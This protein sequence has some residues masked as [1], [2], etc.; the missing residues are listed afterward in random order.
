MGYNLPAKHLWKMAH[1]DLD[2]ARAEDV[3]MLLALYMEIDGSFHRLRI[4]HDTN[5]DDDSGDDSVAPWH[6][7]HISDPTHFHLRQ[8]DSTDQTIYNNMLIL[9]E[10][11]QDLRDTW[12]SKNDEE[13][14]LNVPFNVP[15]SKRLRLEWIEVEDLAKLSGFEDA[16]LTVIDCIRL[17]I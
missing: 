2:Q 10:E 8:D 9:V 11:L 17:K 12:L 3:Q 15:S 14:P 4:Q 13:D 5:N 6:F 1:S 16:M 7:R